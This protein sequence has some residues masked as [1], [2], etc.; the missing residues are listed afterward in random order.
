MGEADGGGDGRAAG[1][2]GEDA[3]FAGEAAGHFDGFVGGHLFHAVHEGEVEVV[4]DE[5]CADALNVMGGGLEGFAGEALRNDGAFP[6]FD[7]DGED[8]FAF[9]FLDV[10]GD[11]GDCLLY[12]S[13]CV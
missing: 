3:F 8:G 2:A 9:G 6:G 12:T 7:G 4:R 5:A 13:R 11:A 10:A 1:Y